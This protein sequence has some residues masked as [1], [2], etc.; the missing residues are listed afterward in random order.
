MKYLENDD[1]SRAL[2]EETANREQ[3]NKYNNHKTPFSLS[4]IDGV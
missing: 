3:V 2:A 4:E 1:L